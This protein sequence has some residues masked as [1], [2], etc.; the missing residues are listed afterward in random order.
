MVRHMALLRGTPKDLTIQQLTMNLR[1]SPAQPYLSSLANFGS[2][3]GKE[4]L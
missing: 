3:L 1:A 2:Q 4:G